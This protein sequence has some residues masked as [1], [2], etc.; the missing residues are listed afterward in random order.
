[1]DRHGERC[2]LNYERWTHIINLMPIFFQPPN[3]ISIINNWK[4]NNQPNEYKTRT[5]NYDLLRA[6]NNIVD[7]HRTNTSKNQKQEKERNLMK[8][9]EPTQHVQCSVNENRELYTYFYI[10]TFLL[11]ER[12]CTT[13]AIRISNQNS[14]L[15]YSIEKWQW[16][17]GTMSK[18]NG[19][20][21][22]AALK[23]SIKQHSNIKTI[24]KRP[25]F[26]RIEKWEN[27]FGPK[28]KLNWW[29][30]SKNE[31]SNINIWIHLGTNTNTLP[32]SF[33]I[34]SMHKYIFGTWR[35]YAHT[36]TRIHKFKALLWRLFNNGGRYRS[37]QIRGKSYYVSMGELVLFGHFV[38]S[39]SFSYQTNGAPLIYFSLSTLNRKRFDKVYERP[40]Y[41]RPRLRTWGKLT[42]HWAPT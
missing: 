17:K 28:W 15:K 26:A 14:Q 12:T 34:Y 31:I 42:K 5:K 13:I 7:V 3:T 32:F 8:N 1:M 2:V 36:H 11:K 37:N 24:V 16:V 6:Y 27:C 18:I 39:L 23:L 25:G 10:Y 21:F 9:K 33:Q 19:M 30:K 22:L 4:I 41:Y 38:L 20:V 29:R 40:Q 35:T